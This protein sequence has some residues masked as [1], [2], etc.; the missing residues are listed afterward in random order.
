[1][2]IPP[3]FLRTQPPYQSL[4]GHNGSSIRSVC[5]AVSPQRYI[6]YQK[7]LFITSNKIILFALQEG[8][9]MDIMINDL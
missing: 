6:S 1:M 8:A 3:L 9:N 5:I 2:L 4:E 7:P